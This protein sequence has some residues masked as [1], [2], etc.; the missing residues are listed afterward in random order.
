MGRQATEVVIVIESGMRLLFAA[1][2]DTSSHYDVDKRAIG[3]YCFFV[4]VIKRAA[5]AS[6]E[7]AF[8]HVPRMTFFARD[9]GNY[10]DLTYP[11]SRRAGDDL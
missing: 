6:S 9:S 1:V 4:L 11:Q 8:A 2:D 5:V 3:C 10:R 7:V